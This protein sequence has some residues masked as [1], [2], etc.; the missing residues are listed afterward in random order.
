MTLSMMPE[1]HVCVET[2]GN[3]AHRVA[4]GEPYGKG[5]LYFF[6]FTYDRK[7]GCTACHSVAIKIIIIHVIEVVISITT[8]I[9]YLHNYI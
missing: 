2:G 1:S 9:T 4:N 5:G 6:G 7:E 8:I 3:I